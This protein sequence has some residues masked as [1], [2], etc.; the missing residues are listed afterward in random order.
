MPYWNQLE[1]LA[2]YSAH[3]RHINVCTENNCDG[4]V[5]EGGACRQS[6]LPEEEVC[7]YYKKCAQTLLAL[8]LGLAGIVGLGVVHPEKVVLLL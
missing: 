1:W 7:L 5:P 6:H 8:L 3:F 4:G 2:V